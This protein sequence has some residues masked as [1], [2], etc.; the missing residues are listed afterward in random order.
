MSC[1]LGIEFGSTRIKATVID[2]NYVPVSSGDYTWAS[3]LVDGVWTYELSEAIAGLKT[4]LSKLEHR[5]GITAMGISGSKMK[6]TTINCILWCGLH[7]ALS[8][9]CM[10]GI[11]PILWL[12]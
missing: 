10:L 8:V 5:D 6:E 4:A 1:F 2:E 11:L 3:D 12:V 7:Y 9:V